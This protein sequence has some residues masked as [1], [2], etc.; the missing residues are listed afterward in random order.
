MHVAEGE[1]G[2]EVPMIEFAKT[3]F[4]EGTKV[5]TLHLLMA[6]EHPSKPIED[7]VA[8]PVFRES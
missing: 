1:W 3:I 5:F 7:D 8:V 4:V 2:S 6:A